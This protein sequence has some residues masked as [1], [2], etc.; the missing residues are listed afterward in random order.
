METDAASPVLLPKG[1]VTNSTTIYQEV[2]SYST[3]PADRIFKYWHGEYILSGN[4]NGSSVE[5]D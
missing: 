5:A 2:A 3:I 1:I 4:L